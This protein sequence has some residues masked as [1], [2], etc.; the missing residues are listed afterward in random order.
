MFQPAIIILIYKFVFWQKSTKKLNNN[1][2][3]LFQILHIKQTHHIFYSQ[4]KSGSSPRY[5]QMKSFFSRNFSYFCR[6]SLL[7]LHHS[8]LFAMALFLLQI[9]IKYPTWS[10]VLV[11][12]KLT[13]ICGV[14]TEIKS[15]TSTKLTQVPYV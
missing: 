3:D 9:L 1:N 6:F 2:V 12:L 8:S 13:R 7:M 14:S 15:S 11:D 4:R 5:F 10:L